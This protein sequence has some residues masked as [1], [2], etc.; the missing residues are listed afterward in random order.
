MC[1]PERC[2][3]HQLV[4]HMGVSVY[5]AC[6][7]PVYVYKKDS[8]LT[9]SC[10]MGRTLLHFFK[11]VLKPVPVLITSLLSIHSMETRGLTLETVA[12]YS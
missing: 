6:T 12:M 9:Y 11:M 4:L 10:S 7:A 8:L 1:C 5:E 2:D 3:L